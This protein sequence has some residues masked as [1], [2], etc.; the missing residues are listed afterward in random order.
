MKKRLKIF[1]LGLILT[2]TVLG[3]IANFFA[4]DV[5]YKS[6]VYA[7]R[8]SAGLETKEIQ[9]NGHTYAYLD[10]HPEGAKLPVL[11]GLHGFSGDKDNWARMA[12]FLRGKYRIIAIDMLGHGDSDKPLD[13][14]YALSEQV[15]RI[16]AILQKLGISTFHLMGNS[17]GGQTAG[18]YVSIFPEDVA[19]VIFVN[20]AGVTPLEKSII[21]KKYETTGQNDLLVEKPEDIFAY[22]DAVF[23]NKPFM[24]KQIELSFGAHIARDAQVYNKIFQDFVF[25]HPEPLEP[26]LPNIHIPV[27]IIWGDEDKVLH[28]S[29]VNVMSE[30][31]DT[32][33]VHIFKGVGHAPMVEVPKQTA[34][35]IHQF[36]KGVEAKNAQAITQ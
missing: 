6:A 11:V 16:H 26:I 2:L 4:P 20:N 35:V 5:L 19:S 21:L 18:L 30:L 8:F 29:S 36:V 17:M 25:N 14:S 32:E 9:V 31:L 22:F 33:Q 13:A 7:T 12:V 1:S 28:V 15:K 10:T 34:N 24:T 27:Q 23:T 3:V